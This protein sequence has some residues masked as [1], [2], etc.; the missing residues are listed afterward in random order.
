MPD[1]DVTG[2]KRLLLKDEG[3]LQ[4]ILR[5]YG[6]LRED[7]GELINEVGLEPG[8]DLEDTAYFMLMGFATQDTRHI[9]RVIRRSRQWLQSRRERAIKYGIW[10]GKG[11][12]KADWLDLAEKNCM[13]AEVAFVMDVMAINGDAIKHRNGAYSL[14]PLVLGRLLSAERPL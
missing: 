5:W 13:E 9:G 7:W 11:T 10:R 6:T 14:A 4:F 3:A 8:S 2:R 1:Q 12:L